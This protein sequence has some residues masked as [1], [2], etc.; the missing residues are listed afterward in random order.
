MPL[1]R[2]QPF[3]REKPPPDLRPDEEVFLC[4]LTRE[5][6]RDYEKF[7][8]RIILCNSLVWSCSITGRSGLTYQEAEE[9]EEKALKQLASFPAYLQK[10][11]LFLAT[12]TQRSRLADLNDDVFV[13]AKDRFFKGEMV[14]VISGPSKKVC[15]VIDVIA[16]G[17][18]TP[19]SPAVNGDSGEAMEVE[20]EK[21]SPE[22]KKGVIKPENFK[23][24]VQANDKAASNTVSFKMVSR[25]K[26]LFTRD[27]CKLFLKQSCDNEDGMWK[28]KQAKVKKFHLETVKF[29]DIFSGPAPQF[30]FSEIKLKKVGPKKEP[31]ESSPALPKK[32]VDNGSKKTISPQLTLE[33]LKAL[34]EQDRLQ[35]E[36]EKEEKLAQKIKEREELRRKF[37]EEKEKR[38][39]EKA[40]ELEKKRE[41]KRIQAELWR[42]WSRH[43][44]DLECDD[45]KV[46]PQPTALQC[47]LPV[48]HFGDAVMVVEFV[49]C[50]SSIFD[51]KASFPRGFS[52]K[53]L[54]EAL[55]ETDAGGL[56]A[57]LLLMMLTAIFSLQEEEEEEEAELTKEGKQQDLPDEKMA[58]SDM[59][60]NQLIDA[61]TA[62]SHLP[63]LN[64][65]TSLRKL[66]LDNFTLTEILRLHILGS[67]AQGNMANA[68]FRYQ[69]RG[70]Y[71]PIDDAGLDFKKRE[72]EIVS[73]LA[74]ENIYDLPPNEKLKLLIVLVD[75]FLTY[76]ATRD[77]IEDNFDKLRQLKNDLKQLQWGEQKREREEAANRY[78]ARLEERQRERDLMEKRRIVKF[79]KREEMVRREE[80]VKS[81]SEPGQDVI[82]LAKD[83][84]VAEQELSELE[85]LM[86]SQEERDKMRT[87]ED[88]EEAD[89][90]AEYT[91]KERDFVDSILD[92]QHGNAIYPIGR[93]RMYRRY[94]MFKSIPGIFIEDDEQ[95][96]LPE[97]LHA[98][99]QN[100]LGSTFDLNDPFTAPPKLNQTKPSETS[101]QP[102]VAESS[103]PGLNQENKDGS[104]KENDSMNASLNN[105][106]LTDGN[107]SL[108]VQSANTSLVNTNAVGEN[109]S[110]NTV[111]KE[112]GGAIVI[113]DDEDSKPPMLELE[114]KVEPT[115]VIETP[116]VKQI[117]EIAKHKCKW[118]FYRS[119]EDL[120]ALIASLNGRGFRERALK[121]AILEHKSKILDTI[122]K[123]PADLLHIPE[124]DE[125]DSADENGSSKLMTKEWKRGRRNVTGMMHNDSAHE[126]LELNLRE[127]ILDL[128]ERIHVGSLGHL[129]VSD[130]VSWRDAIENGGYEPC[131]D[132][133]LFKKEVKDS[134]EEN[135]NI[136]GEEMDVSTEEENFTMAVAK[137]MAKS[138]V[139]I[140][141]GIEPKYMQPPLGD[142]EK[143][144]LAKQKAEKKDEQRKKKREED[145][146]DDDDDVVV[147]HK[148]PKKSLME[149]W[150]DSCLLSTS[151]AQVF[152]HLSTLEKSVTWSKS[153]LH[154][155]CRICRRKC[156]PEKILL[157]DQCDRG[158]HMYCLKPPLKHVPQGE[159]FCPD[160]RPKDVKRSPRKGRRRT[161]SEREEVSSG[162]EEEEESEDEESDDEEAE[163][164]ASS[165]E[166]NDTMCAVCSK[167]GKLICCDNCPLS[168]H[169]NCAKPQLKKIPK[170]KWLCQ[171]CAGTDTKAGKIKMNL[172]KGK[173]KKNSPKIT[174]NSSRQSSRRGSPR[175]S[176]VT[177]NSGK[178]RKRE[179]SPIVEEKQ[180]MRKNAKSTS[181]LVQEFKIDEPKH[182]VSSS[183]GNTKVQQLKMLEDIVLGLMEEDEAWPFLRPVNK[184]DAPDY[185]EIIKKPM[186]FQTIK[187]KINKFLYT[188]P[189]EIVQD[190]RQIFTNCIEYNKRTTQE[191]KAGANMSKLFE[192]RMKNLEESAATNGPTGKRAR[193]K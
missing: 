132:D 25:K 49:N 122:T 48:D 90:K 170:G 160:C 135:S 58:A 31:K 184:K 154:T 75:Q 149:R 180:K 41:E 17:S 103:A 138:L 3:H 55:L 117:N 2:R 12:K 144:K 40:L 110:E 146:S 101:Q 106:A 86:P 43:R 134:K 87:E 116:A 111:S 8:E 94:W 79:K 183:R 88:D 121:N 163:D 175:D 152:L 99:Q 145:D 124:E 114:Q 30:E 54:N 191:F 97:L 109:K 188:D 37:E 6:F 47:R 133:I 10:P 156:D 169:L 155:R 21:K 4:K 177:V 100:P 123:V 182:Y 127:M 53:T 168:Y 26:G 98:C 118:A 34:K 9:S 92:L 185:Y 173:K 147:I 52:L 96:V 59:S 85:A 112:N 35:R 16:P 187:N 28:V 91:A 73:K 44:D 120:E 77:I 29:E 78:K 83:I 159:W 23:Y 27:K 74:V 166:E 5:V 81:G 162:E 56:M 108:R 64:H 22:K 171:I 140:A 143:T 70:G 104:D 63:L 1:L 20:D 142:D 176:P 62:M 60:M 115:P 57:D 192:K 107:S 181:K 24:V 161:F 76:A 105:S 164:E 15:K 67:G 82:D 46:L 151:L 13:F 38:K 137:D 72:P 33:E 32:S 95:H 131:T 89:K 130:R 18:S 165:D 7:F 11:I 128:E 136:D 39:Q 167:S 65:G 36:K 93:D 80:A 174:P 172:G 158:H 186:D 69:Q 126:G 148:T 193:T 14:D 129:R 50:F 42:E 84:E 119:E 51:L 150:E 19:K 125:N 113:S 179:D 190:T 71:M 68:K 141:R 102:V 66:P 157:C 189:A 139:Q 61:A 153:I 45:L 178:K